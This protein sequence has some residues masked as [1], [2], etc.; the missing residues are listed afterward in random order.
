MPPGS[1]PQPRRRHDHWQDHARN[2]SSLGPP[3]RP[4]PDDVRIVEEAV[5]E[6]WPA[7]EAGPR[8]L[9]LGVTP[10]IAGCRW[11]QATRLVAL[12]RSRA[13]IDALWPA[14]TAPAGASAVCGDWQAMPLDAARFDVVV[15]DGCYNSMQ[16]PDGA[17][18]L[19]REVERVLG[20]AGILII[21]VFLRPERPETLDD[22]ARDLRRDAIEG[23]HALKWRVAAAIHGTTEEGVRLADIWNAWQGL[24]PL[25]VEQGA[26]RGWRPGEF[27]TLDAYRGLATRC[28]FP[29]I[30]DFRRTA[31]E[32]FDEVRCAMGHYELAERCPTFVLARRGS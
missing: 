16:F 25:T 8:T 7:G 24:L 26:R 6:R 2:W 19:G 5:R 31:A 4:S 18:T 10:E 14:P 29:T 20:P 23:I 1:D 13:I 9:L 11:P 17:R 30:D 12:D 28:C 32:T 15:G 21:R 27:A 3:L 22:I